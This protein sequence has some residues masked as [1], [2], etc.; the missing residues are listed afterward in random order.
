[1]R[2]SP[3]WLWTHHSPAS[4][5]RVLG[6]WA[7]PMHGSKFHFSSSR[8][9]LYG[10]TIMEMSLVRRKEQS[11]FPSE[12]RMASAWGEKEASVRV[13]VQGKM[14]LD[15]CHTEQKINKNFFIGMNTNQALCIVLHLK[16]VGSWCGLSILF[17]PGLLAALFGNW[18]L[19]RMSFLKK[20]IHIWWIL[21]SEMISYKNCKL[22]SLFD[23][24]S[25]L[26]K[27]SLKPSMR[28]RW[29]CPHIPDAEITGMW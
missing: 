13:K 1:M 12:L 11:W 22:L 24:G 27:S 17:S 5:Y 25:H 7:L 16:H 23:T 14:I 15:I 10:D 21:Y 29:P 6:L 4:V 3:G 20:K 19:Q 8:N 28:L 9:S 26:G 2:C 18:G